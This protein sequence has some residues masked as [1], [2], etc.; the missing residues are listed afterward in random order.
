MITSTSKE[1]LITKA[2]KAISDLETKPKVDIL[3]PWNQILSF[4]GSLPPHLVPELKF[5]AVDCVLPHQNRFKVYAETP[6]ASLSNLR[7]FF[8]FGC[9]DSDIPETMQK[10][11]SQISLLWSLLYPEADNETQISSH[12]KDHPNAGLLFYY[13]LRDAETRPVPKVYLPVQYLCRNDQDIA[14]ALGKFYRE[15]GLLKLGENYGRDL[16]GIL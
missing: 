14:N 6:V 11:L 16:G 13:E 15:T 10:A 9:A 1:K 4:F 5:V 2:I 3:T 12:H 8:L 7:R